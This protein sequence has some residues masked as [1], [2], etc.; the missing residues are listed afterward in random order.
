MQIFKSPLGLPAL[1]R[2][3]EQD[4]FFLEYLP[5]AM[6]GW[7]ATEGTI[8][9]SPARLSVLPGT[10]Q[11]PSPFLA[12]STTLSVMPGLAPAGEPWAVFLPC[13]GTGKG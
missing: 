8:R 7:A 13:D 6:R 4:I 1:P 2:L 10:L 9:P 11:L 5:G 3:L 12:G